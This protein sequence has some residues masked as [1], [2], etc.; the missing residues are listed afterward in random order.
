MNCMSYTG[1]VGNS[2]LSASSSRRRP[3]VPQR[4][5]RSETRKPRTLGFSR[6][7]RPGRPAGDPADVGPRL[8]VVAGLVD[9]RPPVVE[10]V[11]SIAIYAAPASMERPDLVHPPFHVLR[12]SG[13]RL[14]TFAPRFPPSRV[15]AR[16]VVR[17]HPD[18]VGIGGREVDREDR[19]VGL[20]TEMS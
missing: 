4:R 20:G 16:A 14:D 6:T 15:T 8:A 18:H 10:L 3:R 9:V 12:Q 7:T 1:T 5:V 13:K 19:I 11:A 2:A 17:P